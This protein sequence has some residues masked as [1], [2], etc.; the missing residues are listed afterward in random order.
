MFTRTQQILENFGQIVDINEI[1]E[2]TKKKDKTKIINFSNKLNIK[3]NTTYLKFYV[4]N[5]LYIIYDLIVITYYIYDKEWKY[6]IRICS[7]YGGYTKYYCEN[8]NNIMKI[9][10]NN[11][12]MLICIFRNKKLEY[13]YSYNGKIKNDKYKANYKLPYICFALLF[14]IELI[15]HIY[16]N[17]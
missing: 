8:N 17:I 13:T 2:I 3:Y 1:K 6:L 11:K 12:L 15:F 9:Y 4:Y 14:L 7:F 5:N 16:N 10:D